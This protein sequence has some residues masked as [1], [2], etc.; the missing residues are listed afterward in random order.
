MSNPSSNDTDENNPFVAFRKAIDAQ[1]GSFF[2]ILAELPIQLSAIQED[3]RKDGE[4]ATENIQSALRRLGDAYER[5]TN[6]ERR[7]IEHPHVTTPSAQQK[8]RES[9]YTH[10]IQQKQEENFRTRW[11]LDDGEFKFS[12]LPEPPLRRAWPDRSFFAFSPYS[13]LHLEN[14]YWGDLQRHN[15]LRPEIIWRDAFEDLL[16]TSQTAANP[17]ALDGA[18]AEYQMQLMHLENQ[19]HRPKM[20]V[21]DPEQESPGGHART[22][23]RRPTPALWLQHL[24]TNDLVDD[25]KFHTLAHLVDTTMP[26]GM[27]D[28]DPTAFSKQ[29]KEHPSAQMHYRTTSTSTT[30]TRTRNDDGHV[31]I[32]TVTETRFPDGT[33]Q[34]TQNVSERVDGANA[35]QKAREEE[36][37]EKVKQSKD[38]LEHHE[39]A[40]RRHR[41]L[42]QKAKQRVAA[43]EAE[44]RTRMQAKARALGI[45]PIS[46]AERLSGLGLWPEIDTRV[47]RALKQEFADEMCR[48]V[49]AEGCDDDEEIAEVMPN[50][51]W[52]MSNL[53]DGSGKKSASGK[54]G[55]LKWT[56]S[57]TWV[58]EDRDA[59]E[60]EKEKLS[61]L[62]RKDKQEEAPRTEDKSGSGKIGGMNWSWSTKWDAEDKKKEKETSGM[63]E[64]NAMKGKEAMTEHEAAKTKEWS[65]GFNWGEEN[66]KAKRDAKEKAK[67]RE[68]EKA[69]AE[70]RE[71]EALSEKE[72]EKEK[73]APKTWSWYWSW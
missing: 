69:R 4:A 36:W 72:K 54:I 10:A 59:K 68:T 43:F 44:G 13:P 22:F 29:P 73:S 39:A 56:W 12:K 5:S 24:C 28:A 6:P 17:N 41:E 8:D 21:H 57:T 66:E 23:H 32:S 31:V 7:Q 50:I 51:P 34:R 64:P 52:G 46:P 2:N 58:E 63:K 26:S 15:H 20:L 33:V 65:W 38:Q 18:L 37:E 61:A 55:G 47:Y 19:K 53:G 3:L 11:S 49:E 25:D 70:L 9:V 27:Y 16:R 71:P 35:P 1:A 67:A 45:W 14:R 60:R 40:M 42:Q 30:T 62:E 48:Q